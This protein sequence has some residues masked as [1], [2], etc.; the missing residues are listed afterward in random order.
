MKMK[1]QIQ[2]PILSDL[3]ALSIERTE[4][5]LSKLEVEFV[6]KSA[7]TTWHCTGHSKYGKSHEVS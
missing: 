4:L 2:N 7:C 3:K 6:K 5:I 1:N